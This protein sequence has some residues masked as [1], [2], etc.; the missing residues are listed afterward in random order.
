MVICTNVQTDCLRFILFLKHKI[1]IVWHEYFI[2][3]NNFKNKHVK[4]NIK[5]ASWIIY[6]AKKRSFCHNKK[7]RLSGVAQFLLNFNLLL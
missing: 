6:L 1:N 5:T 2:N 7:L 4:H 3:N